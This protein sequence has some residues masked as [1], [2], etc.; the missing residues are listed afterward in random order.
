MTKQVFL[1]ELKKKLWRL[2]ADEREERISFYGEMV[3]DRIE[4]GMSEEEAIQS[5]GS[6]D[7]IIFDILEEKRVSSTLLTKEPSRKRMKAG[8][9]L[10]LILGSP[11]WIAFIAVAFAVG[12]SL[13]ASLWSV[14]V[15]VWAGAIS[16]P[17][18]SVGGMIYSAFLLVEGE[19]AYALALLGC[20]IFALG[21]SVFFL[22]GA[23]YLTVGA[24]RLSKKTFCCIFRRRREKE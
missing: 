3:D 20:A 5:I 17:L 1:Y 10:L 2:P 18:A 9:I 13:F 7:A 8:E 19:F 12:I 4:E 6:V 15:S 22:Y 21:L 24:L 11:L 14:V 23:K 16:L